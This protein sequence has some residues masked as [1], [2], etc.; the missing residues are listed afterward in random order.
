MSSHV[1]KIK[2]GTTISRMALN[3]FRWIKTGSRRKIMYSIS[4]YRNFQ[5]KNRI[6]SH[7]QKT[8]K[9]N[10]IIFISLSKENYKRTFKI[11]I[12]TNLITGLHEILEKTA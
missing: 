6:K 7:M 12:K 1:Y 4:N 9:I 10:T 5:E 11:K 2:F 3:H 8:P